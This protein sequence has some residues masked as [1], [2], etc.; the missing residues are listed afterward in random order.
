MVNL[1]K[2]EF[3]KIVFHAFIII[4]LII[5]IFYW[6]IRPLIVDEAIVALSAEF[7][8]ILIFYIAI[9]YALFANKK[10]AWWGGVVMYLI[11]LL[12]PMKQV[13]NPEYSL[14]SM[15]AVIQAVQLDN[16]VALSVFTVYFVTNAIILAY[17]ILKIIS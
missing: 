13:Y 4:S 16:P 12:F 14:G 6:L 17:L 9:I 3:D 2:K 10:W 11:L 8:L 15:L 5:F 7:F 1:R